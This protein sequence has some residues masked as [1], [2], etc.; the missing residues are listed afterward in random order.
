[1]VNSEMALSELSWQNPGHGGFAKLECCSAKANFVF[2]HVFFFFAASKR[3]HRFVVACW[4][5]SGKSWMAN[6]DKLR[7]ILAH[8]E[9]A[10]SVPN[11]HEER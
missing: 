4:E 1:M 5:R 7:C 3:A 2:L 8:W 11:F 10:H 9:L 6:H